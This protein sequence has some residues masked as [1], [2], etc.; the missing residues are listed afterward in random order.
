MEGD[1]PPHVHLPAH[2]KYPKYQKL[3][4]ETVMAMAEG[5]SYSSLTKS[6]ADL[7]KT[8]PSVMLKDLRATRD[9]AEEGELVRP[10]PPEILEFLNVEDYS[11]QK[12]CTVPIEE[13]LFQ[14][15]P[16]DL[17]FRN[18]EP[19]GTYHQRLYM[20]NNDSFARRVR[21]LSPDSPFFSIRP[22]FDDPNLAVPKNGKVAAGMEVCFIVTFRPR[23]KRDYNYSLVCVTEREKFSIPVRAI[24]TRACLDFP[25][26]I[27]MGM[28]PVKHTTTK[29]FLVRNVGEKATKFALSATAPF[30][31]E[32]RNGFV[33]QGSSVQ[34]TIMFTPEV[35]MPYNGELLLEYENG[36][37]SAV[38]LSGDA[39]NI[40][41]HLS[42]QIIEVDP[43]YISL[44]SQK[45]VKVFNRS[46]VPVQFSWKAFGA[47]Q[48]EAHERHRLH[49]E[50]NRME[51]LEKKNLNTQYFEEEEGDADDYSDD[52]RANNMPA[53][54]RRE[55]ASLTRKYKH[56]RRAVQEDALLFADENFSIEP[57]SGEVWANSELEF[58]VTFSPEHAADYACVAFLETTG[59]EQCLPLKI[60]ATGI[61]PQASFTYD[62]LDIG[63]VFVNSKHTYE[64]VMENSGEIDAE[65]DLQP[66]DTPFGPKFKFAPESGM[67]AVGEAHKIEVSFCSEI[68]GE[69]SEHF[70]YNLKGSQQP[71]SVHFKG[72]VVGPTF[73]FDVEEID[74]G[75]VSYEFV[76]TKTFT[77]YNTSEIPM[78]YTLR[79]PQDG[80]M[81]QKEFDIE[82]STGTIVADG[83]VD[84]QVDFISITVRV[85]EMYLTVDVENVGEGLLS[86][87][88]K[89]RI[90][91]E[92]S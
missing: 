60:Q 9:P 61:G 8:K 15:Y 24:G 90:Q 50:L 89:V 51:E 32:P 56:L 57:V 68:L 49:M 66:S 78:T 45:T 12:M 87:P 70:H 20:R 83:K 42:S 43:A 34:V 44:S 85:Y 18:F 39:Q 30:N 77:L 13:P 46:G 31:V 73:H 25:D 4:D 63:D 17:V 11:A 71:L 91:L 48:E 5:T 62:V 58:T 33:S 59:R 23:E 2:L 3:D 41:V 40:N 74:F 54:K 84:I 55:L 10:N 82:P 75:I 7:A 76:N 37:T 1:I 36:Q 6:K 47:S 86:I 19:F 22:V 72:H 29:T 16:A 52:E 65:Y 14:P 79:V 80:K 35:A 27:A 64:L 53:S 38:A 26:D 88:I 81:L 69:F 28:A 21:V 92:C 67:L